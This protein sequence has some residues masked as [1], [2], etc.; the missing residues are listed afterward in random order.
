MSAPT[1][2]ENPFRYSDT[3]KR[4]HS[5][6][7]YLR[8][9][10]GGKCV[11][12]ALDAGFTC[13]NIDGCCGRGGCIYCSSH[14]GGDFTFHG[15]S[16][17]EQYDRQRAIVGKKWETARCIPY[18]QAHTNT[19]APIE[20][21]RRVYEEALSL[22]DAVALHIATRA[23]CLGEEVLSLL[24]EISER[25]DLTVEL[26]LQTVHDETAVAIRRGH[27][28]ADFLVGFSSLRRRVPA[29]RI[30]VHL[31]NGLPNEDREMMLTSARILA[32]LAPDEVKIHLLHV[33]EGTELAG[34]YEAGEY[35]P[36]TQDAYVDIL[37]GQLEYF[38]PKTVIGR[39]TGDGDRRTLLA[40]LWS[41]KKMSILNDIR[42]KMRLLDTWQGKKWENYVKTAQKVPWHFYGI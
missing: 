37:I 38:S 28:Y 14:G 17:R 23:D 29:A 18:L 4:Y 26:G 12:L 6:D 13:P 1:S 15:L 22:P 7:Y 36:L 8:H 2:R 9:R 33:L 11:K 16:L 42:K 5:Y 27:T 39:V 32:A 35:T 30:S 24:A 40:P 3:D 21:L 20:R 41:L 31:I 19:Y 25:I 10:Y 34:L